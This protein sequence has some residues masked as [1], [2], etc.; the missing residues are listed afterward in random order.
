MSVSADFEYK[1]YLHESVSPPESPLTL[2]D[3]FETSLFTCG[4]SYSYPL[5]L[6]PGTNGLTPQVVLSYNSHGSKGRAGFAGLGWD[7]NLDYVQR[8]VN[9]T[10]DDTADD[11]FDLIFNGQKHD[12]IYNTSDGRYHTRVESYLYI[13]NQSG[14]PNTEGDYWVVI[15]WGGTEYRF[16]YNNDSEALSNTQ[17]YVWRWS[18]DQVEDTHG[19]KIYYSYQENP[20]AKDKGTVYLDKIEYNN[21]KDRVVYF[22]REGSDRPDLVTV[23]DQ[24][25]EVLQARRLREVNITVNTKQVR[26]YEFNYSQSSYSPKSLLVS[27]AEYANV[28]SV[29]LPPTRFG[30]QRKQ[31]NWEEDSSWSIPEYFL[32]SNGDD[33]G[34]RLADVNADG[35]IDVLRR[36][37]GGTVN[38]VYLNTGSGWENATNASHWIIPTDLG[39]SGGDYGTRL[40]DVNNDGLVDILRRVDGGSDNMVWLNDGTS[41][42][43]ATNA[44]HWFIPV[45]L[46]DTS[47]DYGTR[48]ADV[49]GDGYPDIIFGSYVTPDTTKVVYINNGTGWEEDA[50]WVLPEVFSSNG[51]DQGTRLA[52]VNGDGLVDVL[53]RVS[54]HD[55]VYINNGTNWEEDASWSNP[56]AF[57]SST[58]YDEGTR[59]ADANGDGL[60]DVLRYYCRE[61]DCTNKV[62]INNGTGW[63]EDGSW[64]NPEWFNY[65][66]SDEGTRLADVNGDGLVDVLRSIP[67]SGE[68]PYQKVYLNNGSTPDLLSGVNNSLGGR[69]S[70][71]YI[72]SSGF[73]N[74]NLSMVFRCVN[75]T[76]EEN[77]LSGSHNSTGSYGFEYSGGA[78]DY[79]EHDFRGF[80]YVKVTGPLD[81]TV[82]HWFYQNDSHRGREYKT[83]TNDSSGNPHSQTNYSFGV[84]NLGSGIYDVYLQ[85]VDEFTFDGSGS[86]SRIK[87]TQY[88]YDLYGN[89]NKTSFVGDTSDSDDDRTAYTDYVYNSSL[90]IVDRAKNSSLFDKDGTQVQQTLY[91]YDHG[92]LDDVPTKGELTKTEEWLAVGVDPITEFGYDS[93]GNLINVTDAKG[94]VTEYAFGS[95]DTTYTYP[96]QMVNALGH[97]V[98]YSYDLG[99]G[100]L[101]SVEDPNG[102]TTTYEY[103][104]FGR[105]LKEVQPYDSSGSPTVSYSYYRNGSAPAGLLVSRRE[106]AGGS[107]LDTYTFVDGFGRVVQT[108]G[109]A[110]GGT[111][112]IVSNIFFDALG[113]VEKKSVPH[114]V[115]AGSWYTSPDNTQRNV[116]FEYD[117]LD[118]V[119][120]Q[121]NTDGSFRNLT[122]DH[123]NTTVWDENGHRRIYYS[124]AFGRIVRVKEKVGS[125]TFTTQYAYDAMDNLVNITDDAGNVFKFEYDSLGRKTKLIDPDLGTWQYGFDG[126]GNLVWQADALSTNISFTYDSLNRVTKQDFPSDTDTT[127]SYD[128]NVLGTLTEVNTSASR[129]RF[130]FDQRLRKTEEN[131]TSGSFDWR[132]I[133]SYD[134]LDRV[135]GVTFPDASTVYLSYNSQGLLEN[136]S[137]VVEDFDYNALGK[138]TSKSYNN[139]KTTI[140]AYNSDDFRLSNILTSGVQNLTYG[141][142]G[143]GNILGIN[144][145]VEGFTQTFTYDDIDRLITAIETGNYTITY[146]YS[147]I[148]NIVRV[149]TSGLV[150][151]YSYGEGSAGPHALTSGAGHFTA[152]VTGVNPPVTGDWLI[153]TNTTAAGGNVTLPSGGGISMG[154]SK[155]LTLSST[156]IY[157][158]ADLTL[159]GVL[160]V[161]GSTIEFGSLPTTMAYDA[162]GNLQS[163]S[164]FYYEYNDANQL[165]RVRSGG[166]SGSI[167]AEYWY[168]HNNRR[169]KKVEY[170]TGGGNVTTYYLGKEFETKVNSSGTYTT[171]YYY[172]NGELV[173]RLDSEGKKYYYHDDHL[174]GTHVVTNSSGGVVERTRYYPYGKILREGTSRNLY[175]GYEYDKN[176]LLYDAT[177]RFYNPE[178]G[179]VI[180]P[181]RDIPDPF[182]PQDLN[183]YSYVR[184]NPLKY[185]DPEGD[186]PLLVSAAIGGV[187]SVGIDYVITTQIYHQSYSSEQAVTSFA[188]GAVAGATGAGVAG[189]ASKG[190]LAASALTGSATVGTAVEV[191]GIAASG[192]AAGQ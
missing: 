189:L 141:Y 5:K 3:A 169:F 87:R 90:W 78:Y 149:N 34:T 94:R 43:N 11:S 166:T 75:S 18:L 56:E 13:S 143:V 158:D 185:N 97:T 19:N 172:A 119:V 68:P 51:K 92:D 47:G 162:N 107:T 192:V 175:T 91:Y 161:S 70:I 136:L 146:T 182:N 64:S 117:V 52:D 140:L 33:I 110:E 48:I 152:T 22:T 89:V 74:Y 4:G 24:G 1:T 12:L 124:D 35:L 145:T 131:V 148:G 95:G 170:L 114:L 118:R 23:F 153:S 122:Y 181:D 174:G 67:V 55:K 88:V 30:Y 40:D 81:G 115:A 127:Y 116:S 80:A 45:D 173:A 134:S 132:K 76:T 39:N 85:Q 125:Q 101:L 187:V 10:P 44:T 108:R 121:I 32:S 83:R 159:D 106:S 54:L 16:G 21:D 84:T 103:D 17:D 155:S 62:Y 41:W 61:G 154:S 150:A 113:R 179:R 28:T 184:N 79:V 102:Y 100:N 178:I 82:E 49:N 111:N 165:K 60:V 25:S 188:V 163:G 71:D 42:D 98:N 147:T 86:D 186:N 144:E 63:V 177:H 73:E 38:V 137:G 180:S 157:L 29:S 20:T 190:A 6:P 126:V 191:T 53:R 36:V 130:G 156:T 138:I 104:A 109:E 27:I 59:L 57:A 176:I 112:Q 58:G 133:Y 171:A 7:L 123:W 69:T 37:A 72:P 151:N 99:T 2:E 105:V 15:T 164:G 65:Y 168:D 139:G 160:D 9:Y 66:E 50:G 120:R 129:T 93:Y 77:G 14:A 26:L 128:E 142:D 167:V 8:D 183:R 96:D 31:E 46:G 135:T